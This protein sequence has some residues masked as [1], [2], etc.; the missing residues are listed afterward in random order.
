MKNNINKLLISILCIFA[1]TSTVS[2]S[3]VGLKASTDNITKGNTATITTTISAD[4]GIYT[5]DGS[6]SCSG[7]GVSGGTSLSF[8]DLNTSSKSKSYTYTIKPTSSGT[9]TCTTS[10]VSLRELAKESN[11]SLS[12]KSIQIKVSEPVALAPKKYSSVNTLSSLSVE[13]YKLDKEFNKDTLDYS[14]EVP[15]G[16]TKVN[17]KATASD[18]TASVK[19]TGEVEVKEGINTVKVRVTAENGNVRTY[20]INITVKELNPVKVEINNKKYTVIRK[21]GIIDPPLGFEKT[22]VEIDKE[23]VLAYKSETLGYTVVGLSSL[24]GESNYYIYEDGKYEELKLLSI[25]GVNIV[26]L[27]MPADKIINTYKLNELTIE[28]KKYDG[29]QINNESKFYLIYGRNIEDGKGFVYQYDSEYGTLQRY[30]DEL[31]K[32][33]KDVK[34]D[35]YKLYFFITAALLGIILIA[36]LGYIVVKRRNGN[37]SINDRNSSGINF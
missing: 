9:V 2:A 31:L 29:Y 32:I 30:N 11:Y 13:S 1:G 10:G 18:K 19:G 15:N 33:E 3:S 17:I 5:I 4:S 16:V 37:R 36:L 27:D 26:V 24:S 23:N 35:N 8:E 6:M 28:E 22:T 21:E 25:K 20:K 34:K 14:L 12:N 7:A